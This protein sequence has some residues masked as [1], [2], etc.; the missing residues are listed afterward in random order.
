MQLLGTGAS[1]VVSLAQRKSD[2][3]TVV[4]KEVDMENFTVKH[5]EHAV[6]EGACAVQQA[7]AFMDCCFLRIAVSCVLLRPARW[8]LIR[9]WLTD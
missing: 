3:E 8:L 4:M 1:G 6:A 2:G 5:M 7:C 9:L